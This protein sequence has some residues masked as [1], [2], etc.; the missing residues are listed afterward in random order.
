MSTSHVIHKVG[1]PGPRFLDYISPARAFEN[2][3]L[4][5]D[6]FVK[7]RADLLA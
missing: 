7:H 4:A 5:R 3:D 1:S 6:G 2:A